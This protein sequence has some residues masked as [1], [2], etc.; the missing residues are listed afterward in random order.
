MHLDDEA[1]DFLK[2]WAWV[3]KAETLREARRAAGREELY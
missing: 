1:Q 3:S 2:G